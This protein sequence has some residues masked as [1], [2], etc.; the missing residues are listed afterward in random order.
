MK[1]QS[2]TKTKQIAGN[3][4]RTKFFLLGQGKIQ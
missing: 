2:I 1:K 3:Q 4:M